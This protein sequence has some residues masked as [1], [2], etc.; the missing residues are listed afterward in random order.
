MPF[1][2]APIACSRMPKWKL[3]PANAWCAIESAPSISVFVDGARSAEPP[4]SS[5]T[6]AASPLM[7]ALELSRVACEPTPERSGSPCSQ[8]SGSLPCSA[9]SNSAASSGCA[10]R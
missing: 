3:R 6:V 2:I 9:R 1:T 8:P 7:H 4:T 10:A 5:G